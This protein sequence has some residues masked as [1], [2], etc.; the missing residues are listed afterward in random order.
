MK[1]FDAV[2][3]I[4]ADRNIFVD[5]G[6]KPHEVQAVLLAL[7][8]HAPDTARGVH[9]GVLEVAQRLA[10]SGTAKKEGLA[11]IKEAEMARAAEAVGEGGPAG[12]K[13][14]AGNKR[15]GAQRPFSGKRGWRREERERKKMS[16]KRS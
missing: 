2:K 16:S 5:E 14:D 8:K 1:G 12:T 6:W 11:V 13:G 7:C 9:I 3:Q 4:P 10:R 15:R